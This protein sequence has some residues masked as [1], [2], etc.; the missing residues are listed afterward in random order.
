MFR[1]KETGHNISK[2]SLLLSEFKKLSISFV[3]DSEMPCKNLKKLYK[4]FDTFSI[5]TTFISFLIYCIAL[6]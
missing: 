2:N 4:K 6:R 1:P 3:Y 5:K